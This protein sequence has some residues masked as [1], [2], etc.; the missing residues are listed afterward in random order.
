M[1]L[2]RSGAKGNYILFPKVWPKQ[3]LPPS[4]TRFQTP[5]DMLVGGCSC[6]RYH[7]LEDENVLHLVSCNEVTLENLTEWCERTRETRIEKQNQIE[8]NNGQ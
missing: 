7:E 6:G 4:G 3:W 8:V 5:C 1:K 2:L